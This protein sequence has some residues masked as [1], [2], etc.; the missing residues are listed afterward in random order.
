MSTQCC[1]KFKGTDF[2]EVKIYNSKCQNCNLGFES[3]RYLEPTKLETIQS[4]LKEIDPLKNF[5]NAIKKWKP[6]LLPCRLCK[7]YI[8]NIGEM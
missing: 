7:R 4:H 8:Q 3:L 5:K 6:E 1:N 2:T